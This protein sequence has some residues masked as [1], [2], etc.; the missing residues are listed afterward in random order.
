[1]LAQVEC[2]KGRLTPSNIPGQP[3]LLNAL[4]PQPRDG[5]DATGCDMRHVRWGGTSLERAHFDGADLS[6]D[7]SCE[8]RLFTA[9]ACG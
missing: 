7:A 2:A 1:M 9:A 5:A 6:G 3:Q 4:L 8:Q